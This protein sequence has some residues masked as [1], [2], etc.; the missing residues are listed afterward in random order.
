MA[1]LTIKT[2]VVIIGGGA[3]GM[4]GAVA[5]AE[6]GARVVVL[7]KAGMLGGMGKMG[8]GIFAVESPVQKRQCITLTREEVF[9]YHMD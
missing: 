6:G 2:D 9:Q 1:T 4:A 3:A 5:A 7:E 8:V